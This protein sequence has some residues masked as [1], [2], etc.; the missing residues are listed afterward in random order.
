MPE[1]APV[2]APPAVGGQTKTVT[3][4]KPAAAA[5]SKPPAAETKP[6]DAVNEPA[7]DD[8]DP[9]D[10]W[11]KA[12]KGRTFKHRGAEKSLE[13]LDPDEATEMIR[14]GYGAS[15]MVAEAKKTQGEA[16]KILA[17]KQAI[18]EGDD[19]AALDAIMEI[20][21]E[22]GLKLL[23]KLRAQMAQ[24]DEESAGMTDRE[25]AASQRAQAAEQR[26]QQ[27]E[28]AQA[29]HAKQQKQQQYAAE[30]AHVKQEGL[31]KV[32]ELL[33]L[34]K[35]F[36]PERAEL[37]MPFVARAW[38]EAIETGAELGRDVNPEAIIKRAEKLFRGSTSD[39]YGKL[40]P[41]EQ[42]EFL[43]EKA[44]MRLSG[45]LVRRRSGARVA[46]APTA[47]QKTPEARGPDMLGD[48]RYLRR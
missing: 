13:E 42:F 36:P 9:R 3:F 20:G 27:L 34:A 38:R 44:V 28:R 21:G 15:E 5:P 30:E 41:A 11:R 14:R 6:G 35:D 17:L 43:G 37:L 48:P 23:D 1:A 40:S 47:A 46:P 39:F 45:E 19:N 12:T 24:Q 25:R 4:T 26:A 8:V 2:V 22:R 33:K 18:S 10:L 32:G 31:Q 7:G 29:E 16:A